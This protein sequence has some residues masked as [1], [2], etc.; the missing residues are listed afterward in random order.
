ME[1]YSVTVEYRGSH[2]SDD[3]TSFTLWSTLEGARKAL[4]KEREYALQKAKCFGCYNIET[5]TADC[6]VVSEGEYYGG[7]YNITIN[8]EPIHE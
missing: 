5:D 2:S 6:F 8:I 4:Q 3:Y 1:V 7:V